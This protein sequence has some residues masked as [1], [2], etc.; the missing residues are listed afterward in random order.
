KIFK[1]TTFDVKDADY[2][3]NIK[4]PKVSSLHEEPG[5]KTKAWTVMSA[6]PFRSEADV[7]RKIEEMK[8]EHATTIESVIEVK[9]KNKRECA[10]SELLEGQILAQDIEAEEGVI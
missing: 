8:R 2:Y 10:V 7:K 1:R 5:A 4:V 3:R 9:L 6:K